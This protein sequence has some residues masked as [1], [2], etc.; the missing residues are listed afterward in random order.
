MRVLDALDEACKNIYKYQV[1]SKRPGSLRFTKEEHPAIKT[2]KQVRERGGKV[3]IGIPCESDYLIFFSLV[4]Y[5][6]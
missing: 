6:S 3:D 4:I 5:L 2:F 1:D